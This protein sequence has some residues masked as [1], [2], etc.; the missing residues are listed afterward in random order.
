MESHPKRIRRRLIESLNLIYPTGQGARVSASCF[1]E[2]ANLIPI[3]ICGKFMR[4]FGMLQDDNA[5][6]DASLARA[7]F[8]PSLM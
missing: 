6:P 1:K 7:P 8:S 3:A 4:D 5:L 2:A